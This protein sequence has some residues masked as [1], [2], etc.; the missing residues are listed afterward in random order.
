[1]TEVDS[2]Y[3]KGYDRG[4][5]TKRQYIDPDADPRIAELEAELATLKD[6]VRDFLDYVHEGFDVPECDCNKLAALVEDQKD[7]DVSAMC[8]Q[9]G[10]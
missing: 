2:A 4:M 8:P 6:V 9:K 7:G 1:M 3:Q 10:N 5:A